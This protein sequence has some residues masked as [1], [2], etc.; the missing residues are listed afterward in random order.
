ME[1]DVAL[2]NIDYSKPS[3]LSLRVEGAGVDHEIA[4][5]VSGLV[6]LDTIYGEHAAKTTQLLKE[7]DY[8]PPF[9]AGTPEG[10][11]EQAVGA[12]LEVLAP[13]ARR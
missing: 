1:G 5:F 6:L 3:L 13:V 12:A 4:G 9:D 7:Y 8:A 2:L 11:G 10:A